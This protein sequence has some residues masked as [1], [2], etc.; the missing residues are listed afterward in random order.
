MRIKDIIEYKHEN[1]NENEDEKNAPKWIIKLAEDNNTEQIFIVA[2]TGKTTANVYMYEKDSFGKWKKII[3]TQGFIG[4]NG[5]GKKKEGD[6]MTPIGVFHFTK[7]FGIADNPGCLIDY[8]KVTDDDWW[9]CDI[10]C[11]YNQ[12]VKIS[13]YPNLNKNVCEHIIDYKY[14]Y[15]YC[16]NISYN[17]EGIKGDGSAIFLHCSNPRKHYTAGCI[18]ISKDE[19]IKVIKNVKKDCIVVI[20][21]LNSFIVI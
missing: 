6:G 17:E 2:G 13:N 4:K 16:L 11:C 15:Q 8:Q 1:K 3:N 12:M 21:F 5:L 19:M 10:N 7:A 18:A 14:L 20:D 9:S